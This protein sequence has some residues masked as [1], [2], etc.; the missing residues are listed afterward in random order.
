MSHNF[1]Q[2][3]SHARS[4]KQLANKYQTKKQTYLTI[5]ELPVPHI[6]ANEPPPISNQEATTS[7]NQ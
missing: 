3:M 7:H 6:T 5:N 1:S 2:P 4:Y